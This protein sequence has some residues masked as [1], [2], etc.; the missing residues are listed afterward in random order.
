[1]RKKLILLV[2]ALAAVAA[3]SSITPAAATSC[4]PPK[5]EVHCDGFTLCCYKFEQCICPALHERGEQLGGF[6]V[7]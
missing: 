7:R 1:M 6:S 2:L 3:T 5:I 4:P